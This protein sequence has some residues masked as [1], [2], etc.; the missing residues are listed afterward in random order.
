[1]TMFFMFLGILFIGNYAYAT[2]ITLEQIVEKFNTSSIVDDYKEAG[3]S[4]KATNDANSITINVATGETTNDIKFLLDDNILSIEIDTGEETAFIKA[5][6]ASYVIDIIGQ[7]QGYQEGELSQTINSDK[8]TNYTLSKEG[9]ELENIDTT[10]KKI[11]VDLTKKIPLIDFSSEY[12]EVS[13]LEDVKDFIAGDGSA[14]KSKGNIWFNKSG[15]GGE[16][17]LLVAEKGQL[18]ENTYKSVL[19]ILE[20]M[21]DNEQVLQ[22]FKQNYTSINMGDKEFSGFTIKVNPTKKTDWEENLVPS[23]SGYEFVRITIDKQLAILG[24]NTTQKEEQNGKTEEKNNTLTKQIKGDSTTV[25]KKLPQA[26][27][28]ITI[29][30]VIVCGIIIAMVAY[31]K[32]YEFKDVK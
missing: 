19:S 21:F 12:I 18:T 9:Y 20:V 5:Y 11:K 27:A 7:L 13:D 32:C 4:I 22:Y 29:I 23:E 10:K 8:A 16:Y 24:A 26:G 14:E 30:F 6:I 28:N 15:Y 2:S 25:T 3:G 17:T 31:K 1:M